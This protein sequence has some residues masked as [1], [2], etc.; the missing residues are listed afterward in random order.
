MQRHF[1]RYLIRLGG[2]RK[3][4]RLRPPELP[5]EHPATFNPLL[6]N[7]IFEDKGATVLS[8]DNATLVNGMPS[9]N[10]DDANNS[11]NEYSGIPIRSDRLSISSSVRVQ[12]YIKETDIEAGFGVNAAGKRVNNLFDSINPYSNKSD[13]REIYLSF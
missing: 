9:N 11:D 12:S 5:E 8:F 3:I 2:K 7:H 1:E 4:P 10:F 6:V 13:R